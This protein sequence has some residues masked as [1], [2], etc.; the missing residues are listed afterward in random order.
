LAILEEANNRNYHKEKGGHYN[1]MNSIL[2]IGMDVHTE[3]YTL[4]CYSF[5]KDKL[6]YKQTIVPDYKMILKYLEQIQKR[7]PDEVEFVC[8]L[9]ALKIIKQQILALVLRQREFS[10]SLY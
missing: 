10:N 5:D 1:E 9:K 8:G 4:C 2:Y 3:N 6:Q 7:Y